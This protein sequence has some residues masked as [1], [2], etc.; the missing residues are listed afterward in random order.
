MSKKGG[1]EIRSEEGNKQL[2]GDARNLEIYRDLELGSGAAAKVF[3]GLYQGKFCAVKV[4][5]ALSSDLRRSLNHEFN[6]LKPSLFVI[7]VNR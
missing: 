4:M 7:F 5:R 3:K 6:L 2:G 1:K